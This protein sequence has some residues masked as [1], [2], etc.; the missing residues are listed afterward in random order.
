MGKTYSP[1]GLREDLK[2]L[3]EGGKDALWS[4]LL[5]GA[6]DASF[7]NSPDSLHG[8]PQSSRNKRRTETNGLLSFLVTFHSVD[9]FMD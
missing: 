3:T 2:I 8:N 4:L 1:K 9:Y 5:Q 7:V 6:G